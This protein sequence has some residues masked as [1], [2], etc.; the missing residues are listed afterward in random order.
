MKRLGRVIILGIGVLLC[1]GNPARANSV[2]AR[3]G[4]VLQ[5]VQSFYDA[6]N[7]GD[8]GNAA[9]FATEEWNHIDPGGGWTRGRAILIP[10]LNLFHSTFLKG[11]TDTPEGMDVRFATTRVAVVTVPSRVTTYTTPDG[12]THENERQIRTFVVVKQRGRW[13]IMQDHNTIRSPGSLTIPPL[14]CPACFGICEDNGTC[15]TP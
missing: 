8:F 13:L 7:A 2:Q 12:V 5:A 3:E 14:A 4:L 1:S 15:L 11:V 10:L 6:F 9:E